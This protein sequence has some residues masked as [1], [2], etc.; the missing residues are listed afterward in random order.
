TELYTL[1][2]H[3]ALPIL[4]NEKYL[5]HPNMEEMK[6]IFNEAEGLIK[7]VT[8]APELPD[9]MEMVEFLKEQGIVVAIAHS[10]ATYEEAKQ[11]FQ[12]DRKST[13]LN[14]SHVSI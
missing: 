12:K 6:Q 8:I 3:D 9:G 7:M 11:A 4:Q 10:N 1:S 5:R 2:L 13:R 14:S